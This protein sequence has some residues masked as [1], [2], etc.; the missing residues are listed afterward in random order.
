MSEETYGID[1]AAYDPTRPLSQIGKGIAAG[2]P[3]PTAE[4]FDDMLQIAFVGS[5]D[6]AGRRSR[7]ERVKLIQA[8]ERDVRRQALLD[9][10]A[11][12]IGTNVAI[13]DLLAQLDTEVKPEVSNAG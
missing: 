8:R 9:A 11:C 3:I 12:C 7:E 6:V 1:P 2:K 13:H 10:Q 5:S 4:A